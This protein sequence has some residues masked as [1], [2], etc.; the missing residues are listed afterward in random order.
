VISLNE[1]LSA[2]QEN[3]RRITHYETGGDGSGGGC[4]CIGLIIGAL[5]LEGEAWRGAHGS[6]W[7][8]R[9]AVSGLNAIGG[10]E[11]VFL[12]EIVFKAKEPGE[13]GYDLPEAYEDSPDQRDYYHVGV[14][15]SVSPMRI[16]HCTGVEGGI[17][18][19]TTLGKWRWGGRLKYVNYE[20]GGNDMVEPIYQAIVRAEGNKYPVRMRAEA[21]K[22]SEIV[23]KIEQGETVDVLGIVGGDEGEWGFILWHSMNG[24]MQ[25]KF[26]IP[27]NSGPSEND[28]DILTV[29]RT[30][31]E[32]VKTALETALNITNKYQ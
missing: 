30:D 25:K 24:Y 1:F 5:R 8:A 18:T 3:A 23:A 17:K 20:E 4:D 12:G 26:L 29:S 14:I 32:T 28:H 19:D 16:T 10:A 27:A 31:W 21:S 9:N 22:D 15:T 13:S 7:A 11:N 6:N 2:I